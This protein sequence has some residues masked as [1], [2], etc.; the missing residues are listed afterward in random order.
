[1]AAGVNSIIGD[2]RNRRVLVIDR[3]AKDI[4]RQCGMMGV[5][6]QEPGRLDHPDGLDITIC[7]A[8]KASLHP[9]SF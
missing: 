4:I 2:L 8:C 5:K 1:L 3:A 9:R 7:R 6:S